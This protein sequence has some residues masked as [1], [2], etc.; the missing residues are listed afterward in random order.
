MY[1]RMVIRIILRVAK[2]LKVI[3]GIAGRKCDICQ[4]ERVSYAVTTVT[5][6]PQPDRRRT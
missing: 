6:L 3:Y 5:D 2:H 1:Y 4:K